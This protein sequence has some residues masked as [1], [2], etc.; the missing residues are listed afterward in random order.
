MTLLNG[1]DGDS[2]ALSTPVSKFKATMV[3]VD[4]IEAMLKVKEPRIH[5]TCPSSGILRL[6]RHFEKRVPHHQSL[7][8]AR[9]RCRR[10]P[11][12]DGGRC[13][14]AAP[15][16]ATGSGEHRLQTLQRKS[17]ADNVE[18]RKRTVA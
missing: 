8:E 18:P 15:F 7:G 14:P 12:Q 10:V 5:Q 1:I 16:G 3:G 4:L 11:A 2:A 6:I 9:C 13:T 17:A